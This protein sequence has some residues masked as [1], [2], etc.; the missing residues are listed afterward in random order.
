LSFPPK[1]P[2]SEKPE[3]AVAA[4]TGLDTI[5][6]TKRLQTFDP[7]ARKRPVASAGIDYPGGSPAV[8]SPAESSSKPRRRL[9]T[10]SLRVLMLLILAIAAGLGW[11]VKGV[12]AADNPEQP[13]PPDVVMKSLDTDLR[14]DGRIVDTRQEFHRYL[15]QQVQGEWLWLVANT[16]LR[17]WAN[18]RDVIPAAQAVAYFSEGIAR[19]PRSARAYRMRGLAH[20]EAEDFRRAVHD[21]TE[22]IRLDPSCASSYVDR[23][24]ARLDKNDVNGALADSN[25]AIRLDPKSARARRWRAQA[26]QAKRQ[27]KQAIK[28]LDE[29]IHLDPTDAV[30]YI[31]RSKCWFAQEDNDRA[32][33][34]ATA[35]IHLDPTSNLAFVI[36][37][38]VWA[39]KKEYRRAV[40][41]CDEAVR[42]NP[43][44]PDCYLSRA[45]KWYQSGDYDRAL[46]D[47]DE[48][49]RLDPKSDAAHSLRGV[50]LAHQGRVG[51]ALAEL[52]R[53]PLPVKVS[54]SFGPH[55]TEPSAG[56]QTNTASTTVPPAKGSESV[57][58]P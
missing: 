34:D 57:N 44:S 40:A 42:L 37:S 17:G 30:L 53:H 3:I 7:G 14:V 1:D 52:V 49:I 25:E 56:S 20:F 26:W 36:R 23:C 29:A 54:V 38:M 16:G 15:V 51:T 41:D 11:N 33:A 45:F 10:V 43:S 22:A 24:Q 28:D 4:L 55:S 6:A 48:A 58:S 18:R 9:F 27:Y 32:I 50:I 2:A 46:A 35:A 13:Q 8:M 5:I 19:E 12:L 31:S 39:Q 47:C 21:A